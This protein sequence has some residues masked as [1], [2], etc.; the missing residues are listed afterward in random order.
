MVG[1]LIT[2]GLNS[3]CWGVEQLPDSSIVRNEPV[4]GVL[5]VY[6]TSTAVRYVNFLQWRAVDMMECLRWFSCCRGQV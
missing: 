4:L 2:P 6:R 1:V 3:Q 5:V